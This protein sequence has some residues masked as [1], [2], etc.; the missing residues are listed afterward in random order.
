MRA[1]RDG[2]GR[3]G[4]NGLKCTFLGVV[5]YVEV[6]GGTGGGGEGKVWCLGCGDEGNRGGMGERGGDEGEEKEMGGGKESEK[7]EKG[8][9][10]RRG[11]GRK[12]VER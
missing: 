5:F 3:R 10:V 6:G 8:E 1:P 11:E 7:R 2:W 9:K 4:G 12:R